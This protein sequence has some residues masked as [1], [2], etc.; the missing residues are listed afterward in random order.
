MNRIITLT[1]NPAIDKSTTVAGIK[2]NN[3]LR[4]SLPVYEAGGGGINISRV[5]L[6]L[7]GTSLCMYLAGGPTG[8]HLNNMLVDFGI[9]QLVVH[10]EGWVRENFAVT[11]TSNNEQYR[12]GMPGPMIKDQ[13]WKKTL[14]QLEAV[15]VEGDILVA[16]GSLCP[17]MPTDFFARV[18]KIAGNKNVKFILDTSGEALLKGAQAGAYLLKPNLGELATLCGVETISFLELESIGQTFLKNNPCE[19][20]VVSMGPQGAVMFTSQSIDYISAPVVYQKSTIGAGD[21]M[22]AGMVLALAQGK[23]LLEMAQ[24]G[25]ACGTA[26]TMTD[27]TQLCKIKDVEELNDWICS[28]S[29]TSQKIKINA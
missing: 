2:P 14:E 7:G 23:S 20:L 9:P 28:N 10:I 17:G 21:S 19:V 6:E 4:C 22:V 25:V 11:D 5:L 27:G 12:F 16:S 29:N 1:V 26:A 3:K 15:L 8:S 18:S 13:E 24:Y